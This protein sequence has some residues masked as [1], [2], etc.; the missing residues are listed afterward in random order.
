[1]PGPFSGKVIST[2]RFEGSP[3]TSGS[4][5]LHELKVKAESNKSSSNPAG[6]LFFMVKGLKKPD[7]G[8]RSGL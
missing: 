4:S 2:F 5:S 8:F 3:V 7:R 1:M 6:S